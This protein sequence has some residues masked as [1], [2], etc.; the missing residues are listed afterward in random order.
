MFWAAGGVSRKREQTEYPERGGR[1]LSPTPGISGDR[2]C[3]LGF[4]EVP[5]VRAARS[6]CSRLASAPKAPQTERREAQQEG[7]FDSPH[8]QAN[9]SRPPATVSTR[10]QGRSDPSRGP[11]PALHLPRVLPQDAAVAG[12]ISHRPTLVLTPSAEALDTF[13][14]FGL[15]VRTPGQPLCIN[16][17][18]ELG[19]LPLGSAGPQTALK[20]QWKVGKTGQVPGGTQ[21]LPPG[22]LGG[23]SN[24]LKILSLIIES[25]KISTLLGS[26]APMQA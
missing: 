13:L 4:G 1:A 18:Q 22:P 8:A 23:S 9:N 2:C 19:S 20:A 5:E 12:A 24:H 14:G 21:Q 15:N 6:F 11:C 26:C 17:H 10:L 3:A 16:H 7:K 25:K